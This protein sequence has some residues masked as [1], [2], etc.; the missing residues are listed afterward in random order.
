MSFP[1]EHLL[2]AV[3]YLRAKR[4]IVQDDRSSFIISAEGVDF[5][6][7]QLP[8]NEVLY[9]IFRASEAGLMVYPKA[10]LSNSST[11]RA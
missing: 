3:W 4:Y 5:L 10:L 1:R 6:E 9:K 11:S 2:F 7:E 8:H